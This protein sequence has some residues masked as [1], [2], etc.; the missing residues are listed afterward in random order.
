MIVQDND[1]PHT[2][3]VQYK[4]AALRGL[5]ADVVVFIVSGVI[6]AMIFSYRRAMWAYSEYI[7]PPPPKGI[8]D[9]GELRPSFFTLHFVGDWQGLVVGGVIWGLLIVASVMFI[10]SIY[11]QRK[12]PTEHR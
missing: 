11:L 1:P 2:T 9:Q 12:Y 7:A 4:K 6:A 3:N 10:R 5:A 8:Y